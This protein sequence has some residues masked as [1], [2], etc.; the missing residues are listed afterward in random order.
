MQQNKKVFILGSE[1]TG[2]SIDKDRQYTIQ[3]IESID[4]FEITKNIFKANIIYAIW[5]D[6]LTNTKFKVF[7]TIFKKKVVAAITS[8]LSHQE[9]KIKSLQSYVDIFVYANSKQKNKLLE[10]GINKDNL[11]FNPFYVDEK[12]FKKLLISKEEMCDKF[13]IDYNKIKEKILIGSFQRD[14][15]GSDLSKPKWQKDP[16]ILIEI[17]RKLD[18]EIFILLL[19]GPR[20]HYIVNQC[21]KYDIEYIFIG[22]SSYIDNNLDDIDVNALSIENMPYLYN[23]IDIYIVSSKS[24]GGPKAIPESVLCGI[25]ILSTDVGFA[26][27][28]LDKEF[29]Y[30]NSD[31]AILKINNINNEST[32]KSNIDKYYSFHLF[33]QRIENILKAVIK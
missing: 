30:N 25:N 3:A 9:D 24:E 33:S 20:R 21:R 7:N 26:K 23:L 22:D 10:L 27:D 31:E 1:G 13:R 16:D 29:I 18:K 8:D 17:M 32:I 4:G 11:Y 5:W 6:R 14:S 19:V 12:I 2:W 28:L 15:L